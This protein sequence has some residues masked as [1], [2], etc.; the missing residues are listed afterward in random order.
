[1]EDIL[2]RHL[3][4][5]NM[6]LH[7]HDV[8]TGKVI[9]VYNR[10]EFWSLIDRW[11]I[12]LVE[13]YGVQAGQTICPLLWPSIPYY[14]LVFAAAELGLTFVV[15]WPH[16]EA[17]RDLYDHKVSMWGQIDYVVVHSDHTNPDHPKYVGYWEME[18]NYKY[19]RTMCYEEDLYNYDITQSKRITEIINTIWATPN[20]DLL[21]SASSGTTGIPK[22]LVDSHKKVYRMAKRLCGQLFTPDVSVMH[23]ENIHHGASMCYYFLPAFMAGGRSYTSN[24]QNGI[25]GH[26]GSLDPVIKFVMDNE[27]TQVFMYRTEHAEYF[28]EHMPRAEH[29]INIITLLQLTPK[30]VKFIKEKNVNWVRT[31]FGDTAIGMGFFTK[32]ADQNTDLETYDVS[33]YGPLWDDFWQ[34]EVRNGELWVACQ[35]LDQEWRTSGDSFECV[36]GEYYF[37]GRSNRYRI[38]I[39][40]IALEDLESQVKTLFGP[41]GATITVDVEWQKVYLAIWVPNPEAEEKL[42]Q[43]LDNAYEHVKVSY[44]LRDQEYDYFYNS[45]KIDNSKIRAF[46][47]EQLIKGEEVK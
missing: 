3:I 1:M 25:H 45:R 42:N 6:Q 23:V 7:E 21:W 11:K 31:S 18:R 9:K 37:R 44:V 2:T 30:M 17:E 12:V 33:N 36:N 39:E 34:I 14:A 27:I 43:Y 15:G 47:R 46:C 35:D 29:T 8:E 10:E 26:T 13:K 38:G 19:G 32:H 41:R 16:C 22:R 4:N 5:P 40:Y 24:G 28:L 20:S